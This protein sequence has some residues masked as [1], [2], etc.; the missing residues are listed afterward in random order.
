MKVNAMTIGL[1]ALALVAGAGH[2]PAET[3][4]SDVGASFQSIGPLAFGPEGILFAADNKAAAI[5]AL[6]L[7]SEA[8]GKTPGA[9]DVTAIDQKIAAMLGTDAREISVTD[10]AI[11]PRSKNA[12]VSVERGPGGSSGTVLLRIDGEGTIDVVPIDKLKYTKVHIGNAPEA[13]PSARRDPRAA[14]VTDM[15][16]VDGRIFIA[17]LSNEE[18]A[19]KLRSVAYPFENVDQGTS[20]EIYHGAHGQWETRSPVY[21]FVPY[22]VDDEPHLIAGYLC[23]PLVK[24]P[25]SKLEAGQK[26]VGTT[27]AELGNRNRPLDMIVYSKGGKDYLLM[28]NTSRGVMKIPTDNFG[29]QDGITEHVPDG[30]KAGIAYETIAELEGVEQLDFYDEGHTILM[31]RTGSGALD[32]HKVALP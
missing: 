29:S 19:S 23:T 1:A 17:G 30:N 8:S 32:L 16:F 10:L 15:A 9:K 13:D 12:F 21:T 18:F 31:S 24:F 5:Y 26:L 7:G 27:I 22:D 2:A 28:S 25:I 3:A 4:P 6:E 11:G 14:T 20:V